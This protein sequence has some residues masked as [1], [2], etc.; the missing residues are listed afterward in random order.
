MNVVAAFYNIQGGMRHVECEM[1]LG[2]G[3]ERD[4][5]KREETMIGVNI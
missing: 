5:D 4:G 2:T 1:G 3:H